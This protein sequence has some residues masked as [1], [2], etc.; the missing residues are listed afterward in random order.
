MR[1]PEVAAPGGSARPQSRPVGVNRG[2]QRDVVAPL[3]LREPQDEREGAWFDDGRRGVGAP[4]LRRAQHERRAEPQDERNGAGSTATRRRLSARSFETP[5]PR[6][7]PAPGSSGR[8]GG[9]V[10][11]RRE[12]RLRGVSTRRLCARQQGGEAL[13]C[14]TIWLT[15]AERGGMKSGGP[16]EPLA[17][18][19]VAR[20]LL[21]RCSG[22]IRL[23]FLPRRRIRRLR[24][25][26]LREAAV[27][28]RYGAAGR[29]GALL[30]RS[31]HSWRDGAF[32]RLERCAGWPGR[33]S[34]ACRSRASSCSP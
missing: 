12:T 21:R 5:P 34:A 14:A 13:V 25:E 27:V 26:R 17:T 19:L 22:V 6:I 10:V 15:P 32:R 1:P 11:R 2:R 28:G 30:S 16:R 24:P 3:I 20:D 31:T 4:L 9:E 18:A 33:S 23:G 29:R 7:L 8:A